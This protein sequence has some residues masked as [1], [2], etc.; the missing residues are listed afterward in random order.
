[1]RDK[2][3][4][5]FKL[6]SEYALYGL[7]FF[8]PISISLVE[9]FAALM[10]LGFI[11]RKIIRPDFNFI[12]FWPNVF[13]FSFF[14][15]SALSLFNSGAYL[16]ISL[17][18]LFGKW[19]KYLA[20]CIIIQD[21]VCDPKTIKRIIFVFLSSAL[22]TVFSGISQYFF[23]IEFLRN[24]NIVFMHNEAI[25]AATSSFAHYNSFGGY[26]VTVLALTFALFLANGSFSIKTISLLVI[27]IFS[28][29]AMMLTFSRGSWLAIVISLIFIL[30]FTKKRF[31]RIMLLVF[32]VIVISSLNIIMTKVETPSS[33][34]SVNISSKADENKIHTI[35]VFSERIFLTFK[36][37]GDSDRFK[38]WLAACKMIRKHP[39]F[40]MGIG[41]FMANFSKYAIVKEAYAHNCYLQIWAETGIF[42]LISFITFVV[43]FI[44]LGIKNFLDTKDFLLLGLLSGVVGLLVHS[45]FDT[46]LY[47]L[48]LAFLFWVWVGLIVARLRIVDRESYK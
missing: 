7:L 27:F 6:I 18:A 24:K 43:S 21:T 33:P 1:M 30:T 11:G 47:S 46:N 17:R 42:S 5:F 48:Q 23:G 26:L 37:G 10:L 12:R 34:N 29:V 8:I 39:F 35:S 45:F 31:K 4:I 14:L 15:F 16:N 32:A 22:L 41:T 13:L 36:S 19:M 2:F 9:I 40:G 20:I 38:Y 44:Y 25:R 28:I 3:Y